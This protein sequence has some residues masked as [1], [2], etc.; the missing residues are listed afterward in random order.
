MED[1]NDRSADRAAA[2]RSWPVRK[3]E[4]GTEPADDLS[5]ITTPE[6]RLAMMW[7]LALEAWE[8]AGRPLPGYARNETPV[9]CVRGGVA[10]SA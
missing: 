5:A 3:Y 10:G 2:R 4:L 7:P 6:E 8:L 9:R 1:A